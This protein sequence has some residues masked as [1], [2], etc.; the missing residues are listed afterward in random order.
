MSAASRTT[1]RVM[2]TPTVPSCRSSGSRSST[3]AVTV[4]TSRGR[5]DLTRPGGHPART[6]GDARGPSVRY[7]AGPSGPPADDP[8]LELHRDE[9]GGRGDRVRTGDPAVRLELGAEENGA[10]LVVVGAR[11][12]SAAHRLLLGSVSTR[13]LHHARRPVLVVR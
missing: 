5:A 7:P 2:A 11:G 6:G 3:V 12:H 10:D 4:I 8:L 1:S 9:G 13:L